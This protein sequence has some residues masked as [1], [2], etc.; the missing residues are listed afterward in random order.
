MTE[1]RPAAGLTLVVRRRISA[2]PDRLFRAWTIAEEFV[3]WWGP[4]GVVCEGAEIDLRIG[5]AYRIANRTPDGTLVWISGMFEAIQ[6]P[7]RLAFTWRVDRSPA[8]ESRVTVT[9][10]A[11]GNETEVVVV[12]EQI[13]SEATRE[14]H[15]LGWIGCLNGLAE[16]IAP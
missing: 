4:R 11:I 1:Q 9:F 6:P 14:D 7:T 8:E 3:R 10:T 13:A 5:G 15:E 2:S 16:H 12:H